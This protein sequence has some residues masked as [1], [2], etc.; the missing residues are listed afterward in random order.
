MKKISTQLVCVLNK[1][2]TEILLV[3]QQTIF[4]EN[5]FDNTVQYSNF[6][7]FVIITVK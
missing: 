6:R 5:I 2:S 1:F 7:H 4:I 3:M